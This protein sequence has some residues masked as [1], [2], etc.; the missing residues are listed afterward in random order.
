MPERVCP[1]W[2]GYLLICPWRRFW[3]DPAVFVAPYVSAGMTVL[4]PGPG[5]GYFTLEIARRVGASGRVVAVDI[6]AR[7][8]DR[9]RR[10]LE[11]AG[12]LERV[13]VRLA[14]PDAMGV[15]DLAGQVD[16]V[17]AF[18]VVHEMPDRAAFFHE[19]HQ[20]LRPG[21]SLLL[22]EPQGHVKAELFETELVEA[23]SAG[24]RLGERPALPRSRAALLEK[25]E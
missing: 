11:R 5:M 3:Q 13:D 4:E 24:F 2:V 19:A 7:M 6:Q 25:G 23:A 9:L 20:C 12:L 16:F 14:R 10:R 17:F 1:W 8:L 22:A 21:G 15:A 18:A